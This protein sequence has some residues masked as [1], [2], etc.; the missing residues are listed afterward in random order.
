MAEIRTVT[1]LR[2]KRDEIAASIRL[3]ER[4]LEQ[5]KADLQ[6]VLAAI[7][8]FEASG[9]PK[10]ATRYMDIHRLFKRGETWALCREALAANGPMTTKELVDVLMKARKLPAGDKVMNRAL[11]Q[12]LVNSLGKQE[13]RGKLVREGKRKGVI[14]WRLPPEK[15][16]I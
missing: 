12:K 1:T 10:D 6:H 13:L 2:Y 11:G 14:I 15:T 16:L 5:A 9:D 7:R 8:I 3:Y 4:Q